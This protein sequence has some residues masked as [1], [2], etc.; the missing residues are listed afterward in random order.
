MSMAITSEKTG[1]DPTSAEAGAG[2]AEEKIEAVKRLLPARTREIRTTKNVLP[3]RS[4]EKL[5]S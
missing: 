4:P 3:C 2:S 1:V 5:I